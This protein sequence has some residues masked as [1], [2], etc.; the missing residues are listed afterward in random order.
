MLRTARRRAIA[1]AASVSL[2]AALAVTLPAGAQ[3]APTSYPRSE[4]LYTSGTQYGAPS[5]W[6]PLQQGSYATGTTGLIYE[7]LF[8]YNPM[9]NKF[10][11][12]LATSGSWTAKNQY[13]IRL[14]SGVKWSDG[15]PFSAQDVVFT[16]ELGKN[17]AVPYSNIWTFLQSV[18]AK[19][20]STVVVTFKTPEY[21][22]WANFLYQWPILPQHIWSKYSASQLMT[23]ANNNPV[24]T[25]AYTLLS[26]NQQQEVLQKN[27]SWW[28]PKAGYTVKPKYIVDIVNGSNNVVLGQVLSGQIDLSN[29]FLPGISKLVGGIGGYGLQ[30]YY[31][32]APYML[33]ANT[34]WLVPNLTRAPMSN[35]NFR[36]ALAYA[37][38]PDAIA[39]TVYSNL[40]RPANPTGLLPNWSQYIDKSVVAKYGF[41]YNPKK[42]RQ[43]LTSA[44]FKLRN[45]FFT[46]P[47]GKPINLSLIV[48]YGW[49]DW[50]AAIQ[51]ISTELK[52]AG[53]NVTPQ[54]PQ[55]NA[56]TA[57][58][59]D[60]TFD[61]AIT[62]DAQ[63]SN[64]PWTYY[65]YMFN[66]PIL[67]IQNANYNF[68]RFNSPKAWALVNQ[69]NTTPTT[70]TAQMKNIIGQ[71]EQISLQ[72][73]PM[74]PL[75]YNGMW[76]QYTNTAWAGWPSSAG[77]NHYLPVTWRGYWNMT[78][79]LMLT[80]LHPAK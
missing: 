40:V 24:G 28:G 26:A 55:Y 31:P 39:S 67:K 20:T 38:N 4:T 48:P 63:I 59:Q 27:P 14:R 7:T 65:Q 9:N 15:Q 44:G 77:S 5:S 56:R 54:F 30:T 61:L 12:W 13:T 46:Q 70:N 37:I 29:N 69:L 2:V 80:K 6:N 71:L 75:W 34:A 35:V 72:Q 78:G 36:R 11:P 73:L 23:T 60:G 58:L 18:Q 68:E 1:L 57:S 51:L 22:Q 43:I 66:L 33:S 32:K 41:T 19:G 50:M 47:N 25:G 49:T 10:I 3:S 79:I 45:G 42:A 62:N 74:I 53:I 21:Q 8:L 17:A 76:A 52:A 64:T 16:L